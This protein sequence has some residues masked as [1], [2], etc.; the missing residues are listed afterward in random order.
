M[1]I[2]VGHDPE[3]PFA[4]GHPN[5][6]GQDLRLDEGTDFRLACKDNALNGMR[7]AVRVATDSPYNI[8]KLK[9]IGPSSLYESR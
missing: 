2:I 3:D 1:L 6:N 8:S 4:A 9:L 5:D 7:V